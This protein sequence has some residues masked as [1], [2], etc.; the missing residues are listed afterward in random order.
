MLGLTIRTAILGLDPHPLADGL[1]ETPHLTPKTDKEAI[2]NLFL[3]GWM[4]RTV[5]QTVT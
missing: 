1:L 2:V 5:G 4:P 3:P